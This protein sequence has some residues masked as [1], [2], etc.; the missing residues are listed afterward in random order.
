MKNDFKNQITINSTVQQASDLK[1]VSFFF[2]KAQFLYFLNN[3]PSNANTVLVSIGIHISTM[4]EMCGG[5]QANAMAAIIE[6]GVRDKSAT[7]AIIT[8]IENIGNE[9]LINGFQDEESSKFAAGG[10][11][12]CP[13]S[14]PG[15]P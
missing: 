15:H 12:C 6:M 14:D 11:N 2:D 3:A 7:P 10:G 4:T 13:S 8:P 9:V 1:R 5:S